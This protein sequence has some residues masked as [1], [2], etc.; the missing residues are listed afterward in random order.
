MKT[1]FYFPY[2]SKSIECNKRLIHLTEKIK[3]KNE[4]YMVEKTTLDF[5]TNEQIQHIYLNCYPRHAELL[6]YDKHDR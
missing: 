4:I 2:M 5:S 6:F 1:F 3:H